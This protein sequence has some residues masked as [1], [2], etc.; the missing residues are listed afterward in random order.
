M[1][2]VY[3]QTHSSSFPDVLLRVVKLLL[4]NKQVDINGNVTTS[5]ELISKL[6]KGNNDRIC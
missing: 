5:F 3:M 1:R 6:K 4:I 2:K